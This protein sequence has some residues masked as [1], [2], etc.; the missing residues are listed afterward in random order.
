MWQI[1]WMLSFLPDWFWSLLLILGI[2]ALLATWVLKFVPFFKTHSLVLK[3]SGII[4]I[5]VAVWFLGAAS[6]EEKWKQRV[7][8]VEKKLAEAEKKSKEVT[9]KVETRVQT[10]TQVVKE[11][12][13]EIVKYVDREIVKYDNTCKIPNEVVKALNDAASIKSLNDAAAGAGKK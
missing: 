11:K 7:A 10:R 4:A 13:D 12:G 6:N 5:I 8:E 1:T 2:L 3:V 9:V